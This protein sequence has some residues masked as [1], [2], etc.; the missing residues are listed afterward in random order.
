MI[1]AVLF[2][3]DGVLIDS[4]GMW[5]RRFNHARKHFGF[6]N[7][8]KEEYADRIWA[9]SF[10]INK[11][12]YFPGVTHKQLTDFYMR[13]SGETLK[14]L[15]LMKNAKKTVKDL[16]DKGIRLAIVSNTQERIAED[17]LENMGI[18]EYF[19]IIIGGDSVKKGKPEPDGILAAIK[20]LGVKK[21][22]AVMIGDTIF[23][24]KAAENADVRFIGFRYD[25]GVDDLSEITERIKCLQ[26]E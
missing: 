21:D 1:K 3:M 24:K 4:Y 5:F 15:K 25:R 13:S 7:V 22:E 26:R 9:V 2:D 8:S 12:I 6:E 23:D 20:R 19:E 10:K 14:N 16:K 11:P 17:I 18:G